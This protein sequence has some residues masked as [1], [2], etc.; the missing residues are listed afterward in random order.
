M[1]ALLGSAIQFAPE[2]IKHRRTIHTFAEISD[3]LPKTKA[4]VKNELIQLGLKPIELSKSSLVVNIK[5]D[6][7]GKVFMLRADMDAL[8][9][10]ELNEQEFKCTTGTNHACGHDLHTTM[11]LGAAKLLVASK[12]KLHGT[13]KLMFQE[14][15]ETLIGANAMIKEGLLE[16]P[17]V[18]AAMMIHVFAGIPAPTGVVFYLAEGPASASS[19]W[20]DITIKGK[21]GHGAMPSMAID[22]LIAMSNIHLALQEIN[23]REVNPDKFLVITPCVLNGGTVG[24]VIPDEA[25]IQGTI[26]TFDNEVREM[27]KKRVV[28]VAEAIGKAYRCE[29]DVKLYRGCPSLI[30]DK[31]VRDICAEAAKEIVGPQAVV[32]AA[33]IPEAGGGRMGGSEDFAFVSELVPST[34]LGL[35]ANL[36]NADGNSY[37]QHHPKVMFDEKALPVGSAI[38]ANEAIKWL[39][40]NK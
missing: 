40:K 38:Y 7:P 29:V 27:A 16:N 8:P 23:S 33:L 4:Y 26:R 28:E 14:A 20:F 35:A 31:T 39:E 13:V 12:D 18:D 24:N 22:P 37:G 5:G 36:P 9:M 32:D 19:D 11:L 6:H 10:P 34:M 3:E 25:F 2:L 21:G 1:N 17:K 30:N 15:E